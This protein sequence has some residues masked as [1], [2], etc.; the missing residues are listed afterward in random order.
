MKFLILSTILFSA[1]S[2]AWGPTGHR[3]VGEIAQKH[4]SAQAATQIKTILKSQSLA[5]VSTWPD[6]IKSEP[7]TYKHTFFWHYTDWADDVHQHDESNISGKLM[8]S[9][10]DHL[11]VLKDPTAAQDKKA[12]SLKFLVHLIGD[13]HMPLH[14][15]NGL[16]HGGNNCRVTFHGK[17]TNLHALWDEQMIDFTKLS[18]T[19]MT[20]F[21]SQGR[22]RTDMAE[23]MKGTPLDWALESKNLRATLYPE[24]VS[25]PKVPMSLKE[26]CRKDVLAPVE[27]LP[28]LGYEYSYKFMP[29]VEKRLFAAGLRLAY[30]LNQS[31]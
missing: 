3:V 28:K 15:G 2:F 13:L 8:T 6:E 18:F 22:T 11:K 31:L 10:N 20:N 26:Y 5:R 23:I 29:V 9:I 7:G 1:N 19:E 25:T 16:D 27:E 17:P 30:L 14:V 4:L 21:V 24:N 12:L